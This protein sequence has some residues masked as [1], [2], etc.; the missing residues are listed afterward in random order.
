MT[1]PNKQKLLSNLF[2]ALVILNL[3][4]IGF[5][6]FH[7]EKEN[8]KASNDDTFDV[9]TFI[10]TKLGF[11]EKQA[12]EFDILRREHFETVQK[13][14]QEIRKEKEAMFNN[15]KNNKSDTAI[16]YQHISRIMM[17]EN[18]VEKLTFDHFQKVRALCNPEQ[19]K[20]FDMVIQDILR[21]MNNPPNGPN[22]GPPSMRPP[23]G[24]PGGGGPSMR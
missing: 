18:Q 7:Y 1:K 22:H 6:W 20:I 9:K 13:L 21:N 11:D 5:I 2:I 24:P 12:S 17:L 8:K 19:E 3:I 14:N 23:G 15:L 10:I 16:A 4:T